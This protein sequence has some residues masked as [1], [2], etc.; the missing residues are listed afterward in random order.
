MPTMS[1]PSTLYGEVHFIIRN[2]VNDIVLMYSICHV[3][4]GEKDDD[5]STKILP[6]SEVFVK[7]K[8]ANT[9]AGRLECCLVYE[10]VDQRDESKPLMEDHQVFIAV[11]LFAKSLTNSYTASAAMFSVKRGRSTGKEDDIKRLKE[12]I[13]Q[14]HMINNLYSFECTIKDQTLRLE[15]VFQPGKQT[16]IVVTIK[17]TIK[18]TDE[19]PILFE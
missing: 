7:V 4:K 9:V 8:A 15:A 19:R 18:Y 1:S 12:D 2:Q 14:K 3:Q 11:R 13:L 16:S 6:M 5:F 17:E 10:L